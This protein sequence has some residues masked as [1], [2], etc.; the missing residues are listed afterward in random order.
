MGSIF[1]PYLDINV[2][3]PS[4][5]HFKCEAHF[6]PRAD[7]VKETLLRVCIHIHKVTTGPLEEPSEAKEG[8]KEERSLCRHLESSPRDVS[9]RVLLVTRPV[10]PAV[11]ERQDDITPT[12]GSQIVEL[13]R[14]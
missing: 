7:S 4:L 14:Q 5:Y 6:H 2:Q 9:L 12:G 10:H 3:E 11:L 8:T 1:S 13:W